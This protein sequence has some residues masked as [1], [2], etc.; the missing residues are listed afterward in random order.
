MAELRDWV[1]PLVVGAPRTGFTLLIN[2][3]SNLL[4]LIVVPQ[5]RGRG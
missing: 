2:V 4:P 1:E 5:N 3:V